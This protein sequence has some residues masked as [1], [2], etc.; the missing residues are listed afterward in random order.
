MEF[1]KNYFKN[2]EPTR[3]AGNKVLQKNTPFDIS[4]Q[5]LQQKKIENLE[6]KP[7]TPAE[8]FFALQNQKHL[9]R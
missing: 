9:H 4:K 7:M 1:Q 8:R 5:L 3:I 6:Q 2:I